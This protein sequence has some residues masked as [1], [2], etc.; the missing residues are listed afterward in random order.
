M[1]EMLVSRFVKIRE[2]VRQVLLPIATTTNAF[3]LNV[4]I[5]TTDAS[6]L[7]CCCRHRHCSSTTVSFCYV[8][9]VPR[10]RASPWV[11]MRLVPVTTI[12]CLSFCSKDPFRSNNIHPRVRGPIHHLLLT[13]SALISSSI[14]SHYSGWG[15]A[16]VWHVGSKNAG[17]EPNMWSH[18]LELHWVSVIGRLRKQRDRRSCGSGVSGGRR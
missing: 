12:V 9:R 11:S 15:A 4:P 7:R 17:N 2:N 18:T 16:F 5:A 10:A 14:A 1:K 6:R 3:T 13:N 8:A